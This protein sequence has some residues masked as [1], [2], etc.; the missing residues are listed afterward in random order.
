MYYE[1]FFFLYIAGLGGS[2]EGGE[3]ALLVN[4]QL[5]AIGLDIAGS[6]AGHGVAATPDIGRDIKLAPDNAAVAIH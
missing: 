4:E 6:D 1:V 5:G 3:G 2:L